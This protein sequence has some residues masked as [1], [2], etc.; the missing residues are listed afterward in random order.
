VRAA[1]HGLNV[2]RIASL[3]RIALSAD[4]E[5]SLQSQLDR[6]LSYLELLFEVDSVDVG[7]A[8]AEP[9]FAPLARDERA[10]SLSTREVLA[11]APLVVQG[12]F[13][14]A[15]FVER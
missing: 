6:V 11:Q 14:V 2:T 5:R 12:Q 13:A 10:D 4:E 3:A 7:V 1:Q 15:R 8:H 9:E